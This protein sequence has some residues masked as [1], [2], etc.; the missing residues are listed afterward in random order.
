VACSES[1]CSET[2]NVLRFGTTALVLALLERGLRPA[3]EVTL[4][5]PV[6]AM[7]RFALDLRWRASMQS[8][9]RAWMSA[10][11]IQRHYLRQVEDHADR[12]TLPEWAERVCRMWRSV[13]DDLDTDPSRLETTLDWAIKRRLF[14]RQLAR[15]GIAWS[16]LRWWNWVLDRLKYAWTAGSD[17]EPFAIRLVLESHPRLASEMSRLTRFLAQHELEWAQLEALEAARLE[18]FE[19]DAK[20]GALGE[21]GIFNTLD[22]TGALRH[23]VGGLDV[24]RAVTEPPQDTRAR[25]RGEVVRRLSAAGIP[26]GA[27]WTS[28]HVYDDQQRML[29]LQNPFETE[30]RWLNSPP[31]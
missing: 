18:M 19:L 25:I 5:S 8:A 10:V 3:S 21:D 24:E 20:F 14:E 27:E 9:S 17:K 30:E 28:V 15:R 12:L 31:V 7:Q 26:Y 22:A 16:S 2:A 29:D 13:L 1:L 23:A 6:R 11:D 4:A